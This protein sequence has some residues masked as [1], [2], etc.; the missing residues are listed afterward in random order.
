MTYGLFVL[1][2]VEIT[3]VCDFRNHE[4]LSLYDLLSTVFITKMLSNHTILG[5]HPF[6]NNQYRVV[7]L[8]E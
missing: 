4:L 5:A 3:F 8:F 2:I 6:L 1:L 7:C